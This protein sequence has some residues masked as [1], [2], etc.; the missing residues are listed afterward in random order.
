[1]KKPP[2][3]VAAA[4]SKASGKGAPPAASESFKYKFTPEDAESM[5]A[6]AIPAE[7]F[8]ELGDGNWKIRMAALDTFREWL[9]PRLGEIEAEVLFR[10]LG[11]K[12]GWNEKNFQVSECYVCGGM[13]ETKVLV[14]GVCEGLWRPIVDSGTIANFH[15]ELCCSCDWTFGGETWRR[16]A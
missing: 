12:P 6:D 3:A 15:E 8:A 9:E 4:A 1:M 11:K 10:F 2:P 5:A 7:Y 13:N 16:K 14:L